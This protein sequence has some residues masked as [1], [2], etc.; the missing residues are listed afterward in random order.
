MK[1][2]IFIFLP[3]GVGLRNF[4]FT[5]FKEIGDQKAYDIT[6]WNNTPFS[7]KNEIGFDEVK[8]ENQKINPLTTIFTRARKRIELNVFDKKFNETVYNTYNF[9]Q[10]YKGFSNFFKSI[11][12]DV[13]VFFGSNNTGIYFV[14]N[15]IKKLERKT[16]KYNYCKK[17]LEEHKPNFIFCTNQ[18]PS[19]AIAPILAAQDLGIPTATFIFSWDNLP[20]ATTLV[21]TDYYFVWSEHMKKELLMYC[22]YVKPENV[23]ISGTPQFESHFDKSLLQTKEVFFI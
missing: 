6:Y 2:K 4:A 23:F 1:N 21:E 7:I 18:R 14:R 17:Q 9:P 16:P 10:S 11:S 22:P 12:V 5:K 20:K 3:D 19:Q 8:I 15:T 13:L